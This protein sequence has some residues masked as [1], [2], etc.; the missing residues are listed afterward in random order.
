MGVIAKSKVFVAAFHSAVAAT[1]TFTVYSPAFFGAVAV[2]VL[3]S[4]PF[5]LNINA[6]SRLPSITKSSFVI[7]ITSPSY[8]LPSVLP[9]TSTISLSFASR[10]SMDSVFSYPHF[11]QVNFLSPTTPKSAGLVTL[12][13]SKVCAANS[14][15]ITSCVGAVAS[16]VD[17]CQCPVSSFFHSAP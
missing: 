13:S 7:E 16:Q 10:A 17:S 1:L 9:S 14:P 5:T 11:V 2:Y 3:S 15:F 4:A 6:G 8:S 12:P